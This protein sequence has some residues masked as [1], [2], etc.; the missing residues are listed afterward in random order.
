[1]DQNNWTLAGCTDCVDGDGDGYGEGCDLGS[2]CDD[3]D[4]TIWNGCNGLLWLAIP[5]GVFDMGSGASDEQPIHTVNVPSFELLKTEVTAAQYAAC[6]SAGACSTPG[7]GSSCHWNQAGYENHPINC[8]QWQQ[9]VDFCEWI[10]GRLPTEAEF[11][12]AARS[13]GQAITYPWGDEEATCQYAVMSDGGWGCGTGGGLPVCSKPDG[14]SDQGVCDLSGNVWE[15]I[16][17]WY[18]QS[19]EGAPTDGS[20]WVTPATSER[21]ARGGAFDNN[22]G[23]QRASNREQHDPQAQNNHFLG[24]RCAR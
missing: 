17:D 12:Y 14:N 18:H 21:S 16:Q 2:D 24:F 9:A 15:W 23:D 6:V 22:A 4:D 10:G 8:V 3:S 1:L 5:G 19:Y 11:E 13:G 7:T 20:A